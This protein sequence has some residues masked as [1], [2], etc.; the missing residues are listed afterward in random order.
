M[1]DGRD[2]P[3]ADNGEDD[4]LHRLGF[5]DRG[6]HLAEQQVGEE[7]GETREDAGGY[8]EAGHPEH[9]ARDESTRVG[10]QR[11]EEAGYPDHQGVDEGQMSGQDGIGDGERRHRD[12]QD[13]RPDTLGR[14]HLRD[15]L[16][17]GGHPPSLR[18]HPRKGGEAGIDQHQLGHRLSRGGPGTHG[19]AHVGLLESQH[20]VDAIAGHRY[21]VSPAL[22][23]LDHR[24]F[25]VGIHPA[26]DGG[27]LHDV[28][29]CVTI[30]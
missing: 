2:H 12:R 15:A 25:L 3:P 27:R 7:D 14:E 8:H 20:V 4:G 19:Y 22:Q 28:G 17:V 11:Q 5:G 9:K 21:G 6:P 13:G 18:Y 10:S 29:E 24:T 26:E 16:D 1:L 23:G 30:G